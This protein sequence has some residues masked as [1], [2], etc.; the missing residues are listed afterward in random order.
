[1]NVFPGVH[2]GCQCSGI[3]PLPTAPDH[4]NEVIIH[5]PIF[6]WGGGHRL[7]NPLKI[8]QE[9]KRL[10]WGEGAL[11]AG[12]KRD[13]GQLAL[14]ARLRRETVVTLRWMAARFQAGSWKSPAAKLHRW[15]KTQD[16]PD[17]V[18]RL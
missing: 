18:S 17:H 3:V 14:A 4:R 8:L 16:S 11:G 12:L 10:G 15:R 13:P 7:S 6:A 9:L 2:G 1:M 5:G